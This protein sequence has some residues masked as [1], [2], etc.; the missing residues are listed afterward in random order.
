MKKI[1]TA[2]TP[3]EVLRA[4]R[5][6][7]SEKGAFVYAH[8]ED[9]HLIQ[10]CV[11]NCLERLEIAAYSEAERENF[12]REYI[13]VIG[14]ISKDCTSPWWWGTDIASR[15]RFA[16]R[17][18]ELIG[19]FLS[20]VRIVEQSQHSVI[21]FLQPSWQI[22]PSLASFVR[23]QEYQFFS[24]IKRQHYWWHHV[25]AWFHYAGSLVAET[26]ALLGRMWEVRAIRRHVIPSVSEGSQSQKR[27]ILKTF[28]YNA[29]A[30]DV[31]G[32]YH[33]AFFGTLPDYLKKQGHN[34][35]LYVRILGDYKKCVE[36][37]RQFATFPII[38]FE[39]LVTLPD[40]GRAAWTV[41]FPKIHLQKRILFFDYDITGIFINELHR[42]HNGLTLTTV[43]HYFA[44]K[45]LLCVAP[46]ETFTLTYEGNPWERMCIK[47][48]R[49]VSRR[50]KVI[51][52]AHTVVPP[53]AAGMFSSEYEQQHMP[54]PDRVLTIGA[55][56]KELLERYGAYK[57]G[58]VQTSCALRLEYLRGLH[59][60]PREKR[61]R[62][63]VALEGVTS[64]Y[65]LARYVLR[66]LWD[67]KEYE[68]R[69]RS[70]PVLSLR[71]LEK[72]ISYD[73]AKLPSHI[74]ESKGTSL[75]QDIEWAGIV[76]YWGSTVGLEALALGRPVIHYQNN[77]V[78][79]YDPLFDC[80]LLKWIVTDR[81]SLRSTLEEIM[82]MP[83][84]E[85]EHKKVKAHE[86][87]KEYVYPV[88]D[89]GLSTFL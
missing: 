84:S 48:L 55:V 72:L 10:L 28:L 39:A 69:F 3:S 40:I 78:L 65:Q 12:L 59:P 79:N 43:L 7:K 34:L 82:H 46:A 51:G 47:A 38:S 67:A 62:I 60:F 52:Y 20:L 87:L 11:D 42:T 89:N 27:Y 50:T 37:I 1:F 13:D 31:S 2:N 49:D 36:K 73:I 24:P 80:N 63:L 23:K 19:E 53:A 17:I 81:V 45:R 32:N 35:V 8:E 64:V 16:S 56:T 9:S 66:E 68:V 22:V 61:K 30:F 41:F 58:S 26:V 6:V 18:P 88:S 70:H 15:N 29:S 85:Y 33:D 76:L 83:D 74:H 21:I 54:Q 77:S 71:D 5:S 75:T 25:Y 86:Y 4:V 14:K 57:E 44:T